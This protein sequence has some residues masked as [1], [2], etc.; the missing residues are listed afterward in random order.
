M[1]TIGAILVRVILDK[2]QR[3]EKYSEADFLEHAGVPTL[4]GADKILIVT[5]TWSAP[6]RSIS[7]TTPEEHNAENLLVINDPVSHKVAVRELACCT[8]TLG[9]RCTPG[10]RAAWALGGTDEASAVP[11]KLRGSIF[12]KPFRRL[13]GPPFCGP[14]G[15]ETKQLNQG[16]PAI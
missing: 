6:G 14:S 3:T 7:Q 5:V 16:N 4:I 15:P 10:A 9:G 2:S 11:Q 1:N 8:R 12:L 13:P